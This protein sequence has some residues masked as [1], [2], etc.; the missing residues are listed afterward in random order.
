MRPGV[1]KLTAVSTHPFWGSCCQLPCLGLGSGVW[2]WGLGYGV[3]GLWRLPLAGREVD[4]R[5]FKIF[6]EII[7][8]TEEKDA[9][10]EIAYCR[11]LCSWRKRQKRRHSVVVFVFLVGREIMGRG[12]WGGVYTFLTLFDFDTNIYEQ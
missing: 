7:V 4:E 8:L 6:N 11:F 3:W 12:G 5:R 1:Y 2:N 9:G 10:P